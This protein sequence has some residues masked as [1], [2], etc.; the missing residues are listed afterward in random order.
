M[1]SQ[2]GRRLCLFLQK[3]NTRKL[4][5]YD[6]SMKKIERDLLAAL[7]DEA[8]QIEPLAREVQIDDLP[9]GRSNLK[10]LEK[11]YMDWFSRAIPHLPEDLRKSF[12][13]EFEGGFF[14]SRIKQFIQNAHRLNPLYSEDAAS[15]GLSPWMYPFNDAFRG[16]LLEQKKILLEAAERLAVSADSVQTLDFLEAIFRRLPSAI[17][18]LGRSSHGQQGLVIK[19]E[20][21][22]QRLIHGVLCLHF[23]DVQ[24]EDPSPTAAGSGPRIDFV[25]P[26]VR[27]VVEAKMT[28]EGLSDKK[29]GEELA[30]DI[31]RYQQHPQAGAF[32]GVVYDPDRRL[33]NPGG[34]ERTVRSDH[35]HFPIRVVIVH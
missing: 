32:L 34:F 28:R 3:P 22:L 33:G 8:D 31:L 24:P 5:S 35:D 18:A 16:P 12:E 11:S 25:L 15:I 4:R 14:Q 23:A 17:A 7:V 19:D 20:Y 29:L 9:A 30:I 6:R 1:R 26:E 13:F 10:A 2:D 27:V 21:G